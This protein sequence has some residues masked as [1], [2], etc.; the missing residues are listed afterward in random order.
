MSVR[1]D[2]FSS[3][4]LLA[5]PGGVSLLAPKTCLV[6]VSLKDPRLSL[7]ITRHTTFCGA[8]GATL[9]DYYSSLPK[10]TEELQESAGMAL[11]AEKEA[12]AQGGDGGEP[13]GERNQRPHPA[14]A[15]LSFLEHL[16]FCNAVG[17]NVLGSWFDRPVAD[18]TVDPQTRMALIAGSASL[19][20]GFAKD[21]EG[22]IVGVLMADVRG[23]LLES[24]VGHTLV[25]PLTES[26]P[27][28]PGHPNKDIV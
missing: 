14:S 20:L 25:S 15:L 19:P 17:L 6:A 27:G 1:L 28:R 21:G 5:L 4:L 8:L 11:T 18:S 7:F 13:G 26:G 12:P 10:T 23:R 9:A 16:R 22:N 2:I 3:L 24:V